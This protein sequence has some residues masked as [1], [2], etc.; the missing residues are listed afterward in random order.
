LLAE[1]P[2]EWVWLELQSEQDGWLLAE[3]PNE[4]VWLESQSEQDGCKDIYL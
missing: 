1:S 4:W 3:S 2:N